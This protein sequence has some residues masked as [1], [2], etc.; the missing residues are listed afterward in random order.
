MQL[1][2]LKKKKNSCTK[3]MNLYTQL[4]IWQVW[5]HCLK[6]VAALSSG[7]GVATPRRVPGSNYHPPLCSCSLVSM[8]T[9]DGLRG[10]HSSTEA[11]ESEYISL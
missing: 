2:I 1:P 5:L 3:H 7:Q 6:D 9:E 4:L 10:L 8:E 11:G